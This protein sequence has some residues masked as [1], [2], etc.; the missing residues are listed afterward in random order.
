[1]VKVSVY[2]K[3]VEKLDFS[4]IDEKGSK[5]A[6]EIAKKSGAGNDFL[7]W[8]DYT[9]KLTDSEIE[10]VVASA[11]KIRENFDSL[12]VC[13]IGGSYLGARA[14]IEAIRGL[15]PEDDFEIIFFGNTLSSDYS[16]QVLKHLEHK[17][18]AINVISK[19]GT[20]TETA[21]SFRLLKDLLVKNYGKDILK[22][23]VFATTDKVRGALKKEAD[24]EGYDCFVI[25]DDVGG[26]YSV[27]T[28]VGL[29]P[30]AVAGIDIK[31]FIQG[32]RDGEKEYSSLNYK[33][34]PA[35]YYGALRYLMNVQ[36]RKNAEM[37]VTYNLQYQMIGEWLKQ[38]F[39]ESEGKD[40]QAL[41]CA[42][43]TFTTDLH[44]MG[45]FIQQ[46]TP[47]LFETVINVKKSQYEL[48]VPYVEDNLDNLNYLAG[49]KISYINSKAYEATLK[50]HTDGNTPAIVLDVEEMNPYNLGNLVYFFFR[51][52]AY[53]A[54][55]LGV[56]PFN[57][58]GVEIYKSNMFT[59]LGK[60]G[61]EKK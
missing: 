40:Y 3:E 30:I 21:V 1:M 53:S 58:P 31:S 44:S 38:L 14:V 35:Y 2:G 60:P 22:E 10:H 15:Y 26:R 61:Y 12:V 52:C 34:N 11:K 57:Q 51:A 6:D 33:E 54:Y 5:V 55:L 41:L 48:T 29:L 25:P 32:V 7:G 59:L 37:Y 49:K 39:D 19:S 47:L 42:S 56:N 18:F 16:A 20:T 17:K 4:V 50:A 36:L 9:S 24:K 45:Q 8:L 46:G 28:P 13:G 23:A 43:A 27:I